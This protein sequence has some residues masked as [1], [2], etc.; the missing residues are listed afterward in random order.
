VLATLSGPTLYRFVSRTG[1]NGRDLRVRIKPRFH[2]S[3]FPPLLFAFPLREI[4]CTLSQ[5]TA[6]GRVRNRAGRDPNFQLDRTSCIASG[7]KNRLRPLQ[8]FDRS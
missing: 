6:S 7:S 4:G 1:G 5:P 8:R 2:S 3:S